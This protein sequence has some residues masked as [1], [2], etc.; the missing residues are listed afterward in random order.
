[1]TK[2]RDEIL[3]WLIVLAI[4][5]ALIGFALIIVGVPRAVIL[6]ILSKTGY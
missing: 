1:M 3:E 5:V 4:I 6:W 2:L